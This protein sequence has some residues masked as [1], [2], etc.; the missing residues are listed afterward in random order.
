M[1]RSRGLNIGGS[2]SRLMRCSP[3]RSCSQMV[4]ASGV[5]PRPIDDPV[6]LAA[7]LS[8]F[9]GRS[10]IHKASDLRALLISCDD[11]QML[12]LARRAR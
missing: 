3:V 5:V 4:N 1:V 12:P 8:R 7:Y 9:I 11:Q 6:R 10:R 2:A